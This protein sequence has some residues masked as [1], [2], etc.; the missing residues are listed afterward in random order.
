M[1][2]DLETAAAVSAEMDDPVMESGSSGSVV[3]HG[4]SW[5]LYRGCARCRR[6]T[7]FA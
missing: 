2:T 6:T 7:T 4:I 1:A 5:K 3:L